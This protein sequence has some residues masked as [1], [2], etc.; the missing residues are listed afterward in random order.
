[1]K[2]VD[3]KLPGKIQ[4]QQHVGVAVQAVGWRASAHAAFANRLPMVVRFHSITVELDSRV[5]DCAS[6]SELSRATAVVTDFDLRLSVSGERAGLNEHAGH[7]LRLDIASLIG[8]RLDLVSRF[9]LAP[10]CGR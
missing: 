2:A 5:R 7:C 8:H 3:D 4:D 1:L 6:A 9:P 10:H